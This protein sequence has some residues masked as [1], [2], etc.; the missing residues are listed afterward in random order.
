MAKSM[1]DQRT[2]IRRLSPWPF[3]ANDPALRE[4]ERKWLP[5]VPTAR[6]W[7]PVVGIGNDARFATIF[8]S[9]WY[10]L[11][12]RDRRRIVKHWREDSRR[13]L[14]LERI[15]TMSDTNRD[16]WEEEF[17]TGSSGQWLDSLTFPELQAVLSKEIEELF[18][19]VLMIHGGLEKLRQ[20]SQAEVL[21]KSEEK[22]ALHMMARL[23]NLRDFIA[24]L[25]PDFEKMASNWSELESLKRKPLRTS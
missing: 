2:L 15:V 8:R 18:F 13:T 3:S 10:R 19:R 12:L 24:D 22:R 21:H 14:L 17:D 7:L 16:P 6:L 5:I 25:Y 9:T 4:R 11:P 20:A 23:M 1:A